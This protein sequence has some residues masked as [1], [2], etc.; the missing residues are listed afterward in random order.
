MTLREARVGEL[1]AENATLQQ[2]LNLE[3]VEQVK[4]EKSIYQM[5]SNHESAEVLL[6]AE[7]Q[8]ANERIMTLEE[9]RLLLVGARTE[10]ECIQEYQEKYES[11]QR[12]FGAQTIVLDEL[13]ETE[14]RLRQEY[15]LNRVTIEQQEARKLEIVDLK[16][17]IT[18]LEA[19][20]AQLK[21]DY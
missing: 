18:S 13:R 5:R 1:E 14:S 20:K 19:D 16:G 3:K 11:L 7:L 15:E 17:M 12:E 8:N 2:K 4:F 6:E 21:A 9:E 10:L